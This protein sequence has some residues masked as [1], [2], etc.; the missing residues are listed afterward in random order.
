MASGD[1]KRHKSMASPPLTSAEGWYTTIASQKHGQNE[2]DQFDVDT[3][4][5]FQK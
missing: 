4:G 2:L 3:Y 1:D 5:C